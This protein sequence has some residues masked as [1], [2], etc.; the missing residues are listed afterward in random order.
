MKLPAAKWL[1]GCAA[2]EGWKKTTIKGDGLFQG[3]APWM[4]DERCLMKD[5]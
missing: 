3:I 2:G 1:A 5:V 4:F